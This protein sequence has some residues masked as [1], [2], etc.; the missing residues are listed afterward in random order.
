MPDKSPLVLGLTFAEQAEFFRN[1]LRL[2]S[3]AWDDITRSQH[4]RAF[5][6]AGA[7][8]ADLLADL[9]AAVQRAIDGGTGLDRFRKEFRAIVEKHGWHGWT[10]EGTKQGEAWR[11]RII[12]E[13]N[14]RTSYAAGRYAQ[15]THPEVLKYY[16]YWRYIHDDGVRN[17]RPEHLAWHGLTLRYDHPF[18]ASNYPPNGWGC[19]CRVVAVS[20]AEKGDYTEPP[21]GW[22]KINPKTGTPSGVDKGWDYAPGKSV[23]ENLR[24]I[25]E[26]KAAKLPPALAQDF[27]A[28]AERVG[29]VPDKA[30]GEVRLDVPKDPIEWLVVNG[31]NTETEHLVVCDSTGK[32]ILRHPGKQR[33]RV[34]LPEDIVSLSY[35][36]NA[37]ITLL[38]NHVDSFSLSPQDLLVLSRAGVKKVTA[39]GHDTSWF[40]AEKGAEMKRLER[41]MDVAE[42][43]LKE[44]LNALYKNGMNSEELAGFYNHLL[45]LALE[46]AGIIHYD[47]SMVVQRRRVYARNGAVFESVVDAIL[48]A[49]EGVR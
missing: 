35:D 18:W 7:A 25:V 34:D 9:H 37:S 36:Q 47:Y 20:E 6:V 45:N 17:P 26:R 3:A 28:Q 16:P 29:I 42:N 21:P 38:H 27:L 30:S 41:V 33:N 1:K 44:R 32:E 2:P 23:A 46:R 12:F 48:K 24:E 19:C 15:L 49:M 39:Y 14:L 10:G 5:I 8:K 22:D 40:A 31:V 43:T 11:T 4:D 13:T